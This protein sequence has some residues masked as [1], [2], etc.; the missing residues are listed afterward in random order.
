MCRS[1]RSAFK[2]VF[3]L[4]DSFVPLL[5]AGTPYSIS[6]IVDHPAQL[7]TLGCPGGGTNHP[8]QLLN[9]CFIDWITLFNFKPNFH[10]S[11]FMAKWLKA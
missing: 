10:Y 6:M 1:T 8:A 3:Q 11:G 5:N 9:M 2:H 7:L 4:F